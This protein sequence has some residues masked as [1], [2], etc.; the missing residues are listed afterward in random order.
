MIST[1]QPCLAAASWIAAQ[2]SVTSALAAAS[3]SPRTS[4]QASTR[5]AMTL[6]P[7][8]TGTI[9]P[10]VARALTPPAGSSRSAAMS[11]AAS[12]AADA[13]TTGSRRPAIGVAPAWLPSPVNV[14]RHR[15]CAR[16]A[17]ATATGAPRSAS[18]RPCSTCSSTKAAERGQALVVPADPGRVNPGGGGGAGERHPG[19]VGARRD[20]S[21]VDRA[22]HQLRP[23]AGDAEPGSLLLGERDHRDGP[24]RGEAARL[25]PGDG[26]ERRRHAEGAVERAAAGHRV[27]V[28]PGGHGAG[29]ALAPVGPDVAVPVWLDDE[30]ERLPRAG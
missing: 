1:P 17:D 5:E 9:R 8:G 6:V 12:T 26:G 3:V 13:A 2:I 22:G 29:T 27:E 10:I 24:G 23:E 7:P 19:R 30:A 15:P 18:A 25:E 14:S 20:R 11:L 4:S 28:A 16:I 21:R